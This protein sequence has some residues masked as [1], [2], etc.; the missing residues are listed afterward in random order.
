MEA[1]IAEPLPS[2]RAPRSVIGP[3]ATMRTEPPPP[4]PDVLDDRRAPSASSTRPACTSIEPALPV[5][6]KKLA[7]VMRVPRFVA[8][9]ATPFVPVAMNA[10]GR[11]D[12]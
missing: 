8:G 7:A 4:I 11:D 6:V 1:L 3:V 12:R 9:S 10:V 2:P 5:D